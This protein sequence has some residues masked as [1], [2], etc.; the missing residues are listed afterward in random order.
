M[1]TNV[2]SSVVVFAGRGQ[3]PLGTRIRFLF[4]TWIG[5]LLL[6]VIAFFT[7]AP[8]GYMVVK[9]LTAQDGTNAF[10]LSAWRKI[11][12]GELPA[13]GLN[14]L[15]MCVLSIIVILAFGTL[16]AFGFAKLPFRGS[17]VLIA[18]VIVL[19]LVPVQTYIIT[20]YFNYSHLR[21]IGNMPAVALIYAATQI[22]FSTFILTNFF[23][24]IPDE[25]VE[26]AIV[27]GASY[28]RVFWEIFV[29][30]ARP[31]LV[32]VGVLAFI[33]VWN[34][35]LIA[36]LF[37]PVPGFRTLSVVMASGQD[38]HVFDVGQLM[39]GSLLSAVPCI[40]VYLI[41]QRHIA[42]GLTAGTGK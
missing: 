20:E 36:L 2:D 24:S 12:T 7:L 37:L 13:A 17:Q 18:S 10:T 1:T 11:A 31:A 29:P 27:D 4:S 23:R 26:A 14:S 34:D 8:L 41:F 6:V 15:I 21:L 22:P 9:S 42:V 33:G 25:L 5:R 39:A 32:T 38:T 19:M 40:I 35:L 28:P 30:L 16:A 3:R